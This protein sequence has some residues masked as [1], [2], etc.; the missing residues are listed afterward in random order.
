M[1]DRSHASPLPAER[2]GVTLSHR[3]H[4][5]TITSGGSTVGIRQRI[6]AVLTVVFG[7]MIAT[8]HSAH[9]SETI[10][11]TGTELSGSPG[12]ASMDGQLWTV[13]AAMYGDAAKGCYSG[14]SVS[15]GVLRE[16]GD[17]IYVKDMCRDGRS[18]VVRLR[19]YGGDNRATRICRNPHGVDTWARCNF[20]WPENEDWCLAAGVYDPDPYFLKFDVSA[21]RDSLG[22]LCG[23][24]G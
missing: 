23:R 18:A 14:A 9:A 21:T 4:K 19:P 7:L 12:F 20:D 15:A 8:S 16:V 13:E 2:V 17:Y 5:M 22:E 11:Q 10:W 1:C 3:S 24:I 6:F